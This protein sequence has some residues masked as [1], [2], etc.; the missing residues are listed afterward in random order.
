MG[1]SIIYIFITELLKFFSA[2]IMIIIHPL[3][4]S[5]I[6]DLYPN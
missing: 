4:Y 6:S 1:K 3:Q 2:V 5:S